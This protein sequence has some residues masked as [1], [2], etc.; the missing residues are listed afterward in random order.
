MSGIINSA[1]SKSGVI[2]T[3]E[4]D[5]GKTFHGISSISGTAYEEGVWTPSPNTGSFTVL[6]NQ[7][8]RI[9]G[10]CYVSA[11]LQDMAS[12]AFSTFSGLPFTTRPAGT[13][14]DM[15]VSSGI[16]MNHVDL[17]G[18]N[19]VGN[20]TVYLYNMN[21]YIYQTLDSGSW[22]QLSGTHLSAGDDMLIAFAYECQS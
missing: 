11:F 8:T 1:G 19:E 5:A 22:T 15:A 7:Y 20:L 4:L 9:G 10:M 18:T 3:T 16:M 6:R 2:G 13:S 17:H 21:C 14:Y 12:G